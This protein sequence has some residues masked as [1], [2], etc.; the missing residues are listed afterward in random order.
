MFLKIWA[1]SLAPKHPECTGFYLGTS[2]QV[3]ANRHKKIFGNFD[4][5][6]KLNFIGGRPGWE[7]W[8]MGSTSVTL[9]F[10]VEGPGMGWLFLYTGKS[11]GSRG[12]VVGFW[13]WGFPCCI[14]GMS[15]F[16]G[17]SSLVP[18]MAI[19]IWFLGPIILLV[20]FYVVLCC[21]HYSGNTHHGYKHMSWR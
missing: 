3:I 10:W 21:H 16:T 18:T 6:V 17:Q 11:R 5:K 12:N 19:S 15:S 8:L 2:I 1:K 20:H 9:R 4:L 14:R 7:K 13:T